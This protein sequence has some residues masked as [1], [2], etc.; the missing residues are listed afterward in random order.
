MSRNRVGFSWDSRKRVAHFEVTIPKTGGLK[1]HRKTIK[2]GSKEEAEERF[3]IFRKSAL[4][5]TIEMERHTLRT[6][7]AAFGDEI[8]K[9][10]KAPKSRE[11]E[12]DSLNRLMKV[13]PDEPLRRLNPAKIKA[14]PAKLRELGYGAASVNNALATLR[15]YLRDAMDREVLLHLPIVKWP[16][17]KIEPLRQEMTPAEQMALI[18]A[19]D[20]EAGFRALL[21]KDRK[22]GAP[23]PDG[24][25]AGILCR[26][27]RA[28][29]PLFVVALQTGLSRGDLLGLRWSNIGE[30]L[31]S[32][33]RGKTGVE[34]RASISVAC[35]AAL[36]EA[37]GHRDIK[38][39]SFVFVRHDGKP[40][41]VPVLA[42]LFRI[43][44]TLAGITRPLRVHDLRHSAACNLISEGVSSAKVAKTLGHASSRMTEARYARVSDDSMDEVGEKLNAMNS[45]L[46]LLTRNLTRQEDMKKPT[47][48]APAMF[49][50]GGRYRGR[51]DDF[52]RVNKGPPSALAQVARNPLTG[53]SECDRPSVSEHQAVHD[54][55]DFELLLNSEGLAVDDAGI[56]FCLVGM[57]RAPAGMT[58]VQP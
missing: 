57:K 25:A 54:P 45:R 12:R 38:P 13:I 52:L 3:E 51:T 58:W 42:R 1:R 55:V 9:Q 4:A 14:I 32:G 21:G 2:A 31:V 39:S 5:G 47:N 11:A 27:F 8:R 17:E 16:M 40:Y 22:K 35:R 30:K 26:R 23:L 50:D 10:L 43:A 33:R 37:L 18:A 53:R 28:A 15:K 20:D 46:E 29:R 41:P 48:H 49:D 34:Y 36:E 56:L 44:K 19:F 6:Y 24:E 7:V